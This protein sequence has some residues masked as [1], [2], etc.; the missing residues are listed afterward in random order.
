[1]RKRRNKIK[2]RNKWLIIVIGLI[3]ICLLSI[4]CLV[5][6]YN[7]EVIQPTPVPSSESVLIEEIIANTA[8]AAQT[9][10]AIIAPTYTELVFTLP[11]DVQPP[12]RIATWTIE[13]TATQFVLTI[14]PPSSGQ[15]QGNC[16]PY[17][18]DVCINDSPRLN[19]PE[20]EAKG[21]FNFR[22]LPPDPL[23]Y[24]RD[25]DGIGCDKE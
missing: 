22:V 1:M 18:P 14:Q 16:N 9:Q 13:P 23:S 17:Y 6:L 4:C 7:Y 15:S 19:C 3:L 25:N 8:Q 5:V 2:M 20:L 21:I 24:D 11:T 10:T 12:T